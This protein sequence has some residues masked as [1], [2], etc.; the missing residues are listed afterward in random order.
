MA[1]GSE[2]ACV[3]DACMTWDGKKK[4]QLQD[5][6]METVKI[7]GQGKRAVGHIISKPWG[8]VAR[9]RHGTRRWKAKGKKDEREVD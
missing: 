1:A 6:L 2:E 9:S 3:E 5:P 4:Q 7:V 8:R